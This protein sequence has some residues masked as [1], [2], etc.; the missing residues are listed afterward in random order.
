MAVGYG[1][2]PVPLQITNHLHHPKTAMTVETHVFH[3]AAVTCAQV[4]W[5]SYSKWSSYFRDFLPQATVLTPVPQAFIDYL[6]SES[7][8][9][10]PPKY[11]D[12]IDAN[13]DNEYSDW[14]DD[15]TSETNPCSEFQE[16]HGEIEKTVEK[17]GSVIVKLNWSAPKD[18][19]WILINNSLQC[20][21]A[22]D[23]YLVLNASDHAAHDL[24]GHIYDECDDK[25]DGV[26]LEPEIVVKKWIRD[27]NPA[28][29][30][31][32]FI[33][34][35]RILGV[36]QRDVNHYEFLLE[37][38]PKLRNV[39]E[40]FQQNVISRSEFPL[41]DYIMDIYIPRPHNEIVIIDINPFTRKWDSLLFTWHELLE[42]DNTGEFELRVL[43]ETNMGSLARRDHS[44]NQVPI[45][46]VDALMDSQ[47][48]IELAK[49]WDL[50]NVAN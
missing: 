45:E 39:I 31:R 2:D 50:L 3:K 49:N 47:A 24:D 48:M 32:V 15:V 44:E 7:I 6:N 27:F 43:T 4:N 37:L 22:S 40:K 12:P 17:Y 38:Q 34:N 13:S 19:R 20:I 35:R 23:I 8:R 33:K 41:R 16:F 9:L 1:C 10:P 14:E 36:S 30:F 29:E 18:A 21:S 25:D 11:A 46:V 26:H 42:K 5:C 28:L